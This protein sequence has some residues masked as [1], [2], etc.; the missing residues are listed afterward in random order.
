MNLLGLDFE[1]S[2]LSPEN[3][4]ILEV[5]AVI[6]DTDLHVP[7]AIDNF[8]V[9]WGIDV[10]EEITEINGIQQR[11]LDDHGLDPLFA[12]N[13][14]GLLEDK[15]EITVAH[16]GNLFDRPFRREWNKRL[17]PQP[18]A[19]DRLW[20][21]T[22]VDLDYPDKVSTRRLTYLAAEHGFLNPFAH[23]AVFDVL[24]M[25]VILDKYPLEEVIFSAKQPTVLVQAL[26]SY[27]NRQ[28]AKDNFFY[29]DGEKK[30]WLRSMKKHKLEQV[31]FPFNHRIV[32]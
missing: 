6:W 8:F 31:K 12:L 32:G 18:P 23:R 16:N 3:D 19:D 9:N 15:T 30:A 17:L 29:W 24:T 10:S 25:M 7:I 11:F 1:T 14:L 26:V 20:I 5:G 28:L 21:D 22:H 13:R 4:L 2:G 27:D